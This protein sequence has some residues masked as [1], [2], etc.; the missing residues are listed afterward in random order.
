[1]STG[2]IKSLRFRRLATNVKP[3]AK[4]RVVLSRATRAE[5]VTYH[6]Y[7]NEMGQIVLDPQVSIPASEAWLLRNAAA[8]AAVV[9]GLKEAAEGKTTRVDLNEL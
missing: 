2:V 9:R 5:G 3:D 4:N 1:M 7:R 8:R 6:V